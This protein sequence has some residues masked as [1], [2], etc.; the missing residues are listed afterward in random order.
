MFHIQKP[1]LEKKSFL[2]HSIFVFLFVITLQ[3]LKNQLKKTWNVISEF[4]SSLFALSFNYPSS[5]LSYKCWTRE[6]WQN[7][8]SHV[9]TIRP[10]PRSPSFHFQSFKMSISCKNVLA[11]LEASFDH[12]PIV[13]AR[14]T[15]LQFASTFRIDSLSSL[16][17]L[18]AVIRNV[19]LFLPSSS[20][21]VFFEPPFYRTSVLVIL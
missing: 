5:C 4:D 1:F 14:Q 18:L 7:A 6:F 11:R 17:S 19:L 21:T 2:K 3:S 20:S 10:C 15:F 12:F 8:G 13:F 9:H 16:M